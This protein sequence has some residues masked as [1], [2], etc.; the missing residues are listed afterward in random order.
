MKKTR[1]AV[2]GC[3][4]VAMEYIPHLQASEYVECLAVCD[5]LPNRAHDYAEKYGIPQFY[6]DIDQLL[7]ELEFDLLV[8]LTSMPFHGSINRKALMAGRNVWC[9]K[10]IAT[11]LPTAEEI[12][13]LADE[14]KLGLWGAPNVVTS[15]AF[16]FMN[17]QIQCGAI[18]KACVGHGIYGWSGP[19]WGAWFYQK[20]GGSLF[21][22]GVYNIT[23][24]TGLLGPAKSVVAMSG[25]AVPVRQINGQKI[26][27]EADDNTALILD[28]GASVFSV[29]QTGFVYKKQREDWTVQIIGTNGAVTMGGYDWDPCGVQL[30]TGDRD[31]ER[32]CEGEPNYHWAGGATYIAECMAGGKKPMIQGA[33][34]VH[35]LDIMISALKSAESGQRIEIA[36]TF[37]WPLV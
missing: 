6:T 27:V 15:D 35:V 37:Q 34:A 5:S 12:V 29:I 25:A 4:S 23:T 10:P 14:K 17:Q 32:H 16:R 24:L 26:T 13:R 33:H 9:E 30:S 18:G 31:W 3:G 22:L 20:G 21:D 2:V 8:N 11:D 7:K 1:V 28:H 36:T 19:D